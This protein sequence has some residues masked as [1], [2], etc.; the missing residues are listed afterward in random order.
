MKHR[1][2]IGSG[3]QKLIDRDSETQRAWSCYEFTLIFFQN[4]ERRLKINGE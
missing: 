2:G 4:K 3:I 1:V